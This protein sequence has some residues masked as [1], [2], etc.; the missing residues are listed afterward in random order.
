M[1]YRRFT[2]WIFSFIPLLITLVI[3]PMLPET[4]P[5]HYGADGYATNYGS[6]YVM[7]VLPIIAVVTGL[8]WLLCAI[9]ALKD[10]EKGV[11]NVKV[12]FWVDIL[13]SL[14]FTIAQ[15]WILYASYMQVENIYRS[16]FDFLKVLSICFSVFWIMLGNYLPKCKQNGMIGIR[17]MWTLSN[18]STWYK[19]HRLGGRLFLIGGIISVT[20]CLFVL[21][22][23]VAL[24]FSL[25]VALILII[26]LAIYSYRCSNTMKNEHD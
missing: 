25:H 7:L 14:I 23:L 1:R 10:K 11:Q 4:I 3:L 12:L 8:L 21:N 5:I 15:V 18:E 19:T 22:G 17:I 24:L 9:Y 26:P 6:K 2:A 16:D 13:A 20:L